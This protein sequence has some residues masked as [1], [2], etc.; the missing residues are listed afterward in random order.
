MKHVFTLAI[1][2]LIQINI[3]SQG[4]LVQQD[5]V[6]NTLPKKHKNIIAIVG[7]FETE[8][9]LLKDSLLQEKDTTI[10]GIHFYVGKLKHQP[11]VIARSGIGKVNAAITLTILIEHFNPKYIL[12][13]GIAGAMNPLLQPGDI[14]IA[15]KIAYHDYGRNTTAGFIERPTFNPYNFKANPITFQSDSLLLAA[16]HKAVEKISLQ[17]I[18]T[19][20]PKILMGKIITGDIFLA[21]TQL[22]KQ[23]RTQFQADAIEMEGAAIAQVCYQQNIPFIIIR[24]ISDT[25]ND[26]AV[27]DFEKYGKIAAENSA[28]LLLTMLAL[29]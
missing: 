14:V 19:E 25:A 26:S 10:E 27:L 15:K 22:N 7:A 12:F 28:S 18:H 4:I 9:Q 16:C 2:S 20:K 11:I 24:S 21:N 3:F 23:L 1:C 17:K 13:S 6:A 29:L 5:K 8:V